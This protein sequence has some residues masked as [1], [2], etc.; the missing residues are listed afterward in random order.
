M[1]PLD[2]EFLGP[3]S[4]AVSQRR[5]RQL[6]KYNSPYQPPARPLA[7]AAAATGGS[8]T[9]RP[10]RAAAMDDPLADLLADDD[11]LSCLFRRM[12]GADGS[13]DG[14]VTREGWV[15]LLKGADGADVADDAASAFWTCC[16]SWSASSLPRSFLLF[17]TER[18]ASA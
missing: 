3:E 9:S 13:V 4:A 2:L 1:L 5:R 17:A 6:Q 12:D 15:A 18:A 10:A 14:I 8:N 11:I 16:W 7:R